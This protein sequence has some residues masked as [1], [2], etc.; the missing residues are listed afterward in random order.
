MNL[1]RHTCLI[2]ARTVAWAVARPY[3]GRLGQYRRHHDAKWEV[4]GDRCFERSVA[5]ADHLGQKPVHCIASGKDRYRRSLATCDLD[6]DNLNR[7]LVTNGWAVAYPRYSEIY[8][9]D[10]AVAQEQ[11]RGIWSGTFIMP[12]DYRHQKKSSSFKR[13]HRERHTF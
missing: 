13:P 7:W 8:V 9:P 5:L 12:W 1:G 11:K 4:C 6:G 10:E 3:R 2:Q